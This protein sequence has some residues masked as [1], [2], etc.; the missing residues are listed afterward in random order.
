MKGKE[1]KKISWFI[2][3]KIESRKHTNYEN[4]ED[5]K[6][7][8]YHR[9]NETRKII[10]LF[11]LHYTVFG[12]KQEKE[13]L[14]IQPKKVNIQLLS[15]V[16]K[17]SSNTL[18]LASWDNQPGHFRKKNPCMNCCLSKGSL[19]STIPGFCYSNQH[20]LNLLCAQ[21]HELHCDIQE[22]WIWNGVFHML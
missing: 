15:H 19:A 14:Q 11:Q 2:Y 12:K 7:M 21:Q 5:L 1:I 4:H 6:D 3:R 18:P 20:R 17:Q 22:A 8:S 16:N 10:R 9:T 13:S